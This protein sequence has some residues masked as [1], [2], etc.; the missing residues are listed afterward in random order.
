M[1]SLLVTIRK[2]GS[3][4]ISMA[5]GREM[6][7]PEALWDGDTMRVTKLQD[8]YLSGISPGH[9]SPHSITCEQSGRKQGAVC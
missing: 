9:Q 1:C 6:E 3:I 5:I 7:C 8:R 2:V 4:V